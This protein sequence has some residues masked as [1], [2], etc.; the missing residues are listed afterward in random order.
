MK[1]LFMFNVV[2]NTVREDGAT[3]AIDA[4]RIKPFLALTIGGSDCDRLRSINTGF[5]RISEIGRRPC[6]LSTSDMDG[7]RVTT[8][9]PR[10][11]NCVRG[12]AGVSE[13]GGGGG[14]SEFVDSLRVLG[15]V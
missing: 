8:C 13:S 5:V 6:C 11:I 7:R 2:W 14:G 10:G 1:Y 4:R 3:F 9:E 12:N 15:G